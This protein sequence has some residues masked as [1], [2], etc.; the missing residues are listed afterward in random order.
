MHKFL[1]YFI[2]FLAFEACKNPEK[3]RKISTSEFVSK[4]QILLTNNAKFKGYE[5]GMTGASAFL[6]KYNNRTIAVTA[7]HL[8]GEA[9]GL[10]PEI[11]VQDLGK[12][13]VY[14]KMYQR[15][16]QGTKTDTIEVI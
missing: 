5:N 11:K 7:R 16:M 4:N 10:D 15:G 9:G 12:Y 2:V 6:V 3:K 13:L 14:W 8:L 1:I